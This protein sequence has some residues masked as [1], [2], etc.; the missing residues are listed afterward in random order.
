M[1]TSY[2]KFVHGG[3]TLIECGLHLGW[4][5]T[6]GSKVFSRGKALSSLNFVFC[7]DKLHFLGVWNEL[8]FLL[9]I[10]S[11]G[12]GMM[13]VTPVQCRIGVSEEHSSVS[14]EKKKKSIYN[15]FNEFLL[16]SFMT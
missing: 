12:I 16:D 4:Q 9:H 2:V 8:C 10:R 5:Q 11:D 13:L 3:V 6:G 15:E 7:V 1:S 14:G